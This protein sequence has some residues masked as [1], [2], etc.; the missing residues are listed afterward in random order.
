MATPEGKATNIFTLT[1][2]HSMP[3]R[4]ADLLSFAENTG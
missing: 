2:C 1:V 3:L 4:F